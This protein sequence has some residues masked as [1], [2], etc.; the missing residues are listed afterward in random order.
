MERLAM[1]VRDDGYDRLLTPLTFAYVL[2]SRGVQV[3]MLFVL[4]A[5]RVLTEEGARSVKVDGR[6][7]VEEAWLRQA[8]AEEGSPVEI[9]DFIRLLKETGRVNFYACKLAAATFGVNQQNLI[10]EASGIVDSAWFLNEKALEA[11]HC[12]YF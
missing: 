3:D 6:H 5:A 4:W 7:A 1:V 2:A 12:Q 8:L 9:L 11:D 10:P